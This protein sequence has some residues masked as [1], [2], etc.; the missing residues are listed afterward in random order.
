MLGAN[1]GTTLIV[2][3]LSFDAS[4]VSPALI[5]LGYMVVRRAK[6]TMLKDIGRIFIG[7]GLMLLSLGLLVSSLAP[8]QE[9]EIAQQ[10]F[11]SITSEPTL[12]L[13]I[14]AVL[15]WAAHS[16]VAT[17]LLNMSLAT[18]GLVTPLAAMALVL[19]ANL[20]S[21]L[22]PLL[23]GLGSSNPMH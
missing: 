4:A 13:L 23:E 2:Q 19:G 3:I 15:T 12:A 5:L 18:S 6:Q 8:I 21:A 14:A 7:L 22:N 10:L 17:V 9:S 20:G 1:V 16:S 11:N